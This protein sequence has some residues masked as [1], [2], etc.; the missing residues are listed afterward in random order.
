VPLDVP[1]PPAGV[2]LQSVGS[3]THIGLAS[4]G[5][6]ARAD[7]GVFG[8]ASIDGNF[9]AYSV[10]TQLTGVLPS[11]TP[12]QPITPETFPAHLTSFSYD[13]CLGVGPFGPD[14]D[15]CSDA[16]G[17]ATRIVTYRGTATLQD[18]TAP[19]P[20]PSSLLLV[21]SGLAM[22]RGVRKRGSLRVDS[23]RAFSV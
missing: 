22:V 13:A 20:E 4:G 10:I 15:S 12:P 14:A 6:F 7:A 9:V 19:V 5:F 17:E 8:S 23:P 16:R 2:A 21:V 18:T 11:S 1:P 3:T